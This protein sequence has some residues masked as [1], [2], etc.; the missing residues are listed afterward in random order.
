MKLF[1]TVLGALIVLSAFY[2]YWGAMNYAYE[3]TFISNIICGLI[4]LVDGVI[5]FKDKQVPVLIYQIA[6][7]AIIC[8]YMTTFMNAFKITHFNFDGGFMFLHA[9]NPVIFLLMYLF[10]TKLTISNKNEYLLYI[11]LSPVF[12]MLYLLFDLIKYLVTGS[13][14]YEILTK[15]MLYLTPVIVIVMYLVLV[16]VNIGIVKLKLYTD[17]RIKI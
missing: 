7:S 12:I 5:S 15:N 6:L 3:L 10:T 16:L 8:V 1:K 4:L 14:V 11:L 17:R 9:M 2:T 13:F